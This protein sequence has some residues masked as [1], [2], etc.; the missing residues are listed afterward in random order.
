MISDLTRLE[1]INE[2]NVT[3][4][5]VER[6]HEDLVYTKVGP[7]LIALNPFKAI[8][9]MYTHEMMDK[10]KNSVTL[11]FGGGDQKFASE[12]IPHVFTIT[13][14]AFQKLCE[15]QSQSLIISGESGAGKYLL[16]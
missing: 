8:S 9:G 10:C 12:E 1:D 13:S 6:F 4:A 14:L 15:G 2:N 3:N 7:I 11:E 5:L 16:I